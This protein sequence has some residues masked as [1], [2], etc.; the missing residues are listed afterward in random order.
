MP[1][2]VGAYLF[3]DYCTGEIFALRVADGEVVDSRI[4]DSTVGELTSFGL[5]RS[6]NLYVTA[7][8]SV[9]RVVV[10]P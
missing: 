5:D 8:D 2:L 7:W 9:Y 1:D 10:A 3:G 4:F 6:G